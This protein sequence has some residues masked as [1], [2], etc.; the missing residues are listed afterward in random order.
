[1]LKNFSNRELAIGFWLLILLIFIINKKDTRQSLWDLIITFFSKKLI[2]WHISMFLYTSLI[3]FILFEIGFWEFRLLKDT[4]IWYISTAIPSTIKSMEEAKDMKYFKEMAKNNVNIGVLIGFVMDSYNF[5]LI[6]EI[7]L[8]PLII[9]LS[10]MLTVAKF[11]A[12]HENKDYKATA[13]L[14]KYVTAGVGLS[15]IF[16]SLK[17]FLNDIRNIIFLDLIKECLFRIYISLYYIRLMK[18]FL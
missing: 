14:L 16:S 7:I 4:I 10:L 18:N 13:E 17:R 12:K 2:S 3:V 15:L 5:S 11:K 6:Y 8:I 9:F 1:M